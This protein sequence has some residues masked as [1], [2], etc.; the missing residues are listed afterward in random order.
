MRALPLSYR[1][2][3]SSYLTRNNQRKVRFNLAHPNK[4]S[5]LQE[6]LFQENK[7]L[8]IRNKQHQLS[9]LKHLISTYRVPKRDNQFKSLMI[10]VWIMHLP[11][12][13]QEN[14]P[15]PP[16]TGNS[17]RPQVVSRE[18]LRGLRKKLRL[19]LHNLPRCLRSLIV[20]N[21]EFLGIRSW[22]RIAERAS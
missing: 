16:L 20:W 19:Y 15:N 2:I 4:F 5:F 6:K 22:K 21:R 10:A 14:N 9:I 17:T 7:V 3:I 8:V 13:R 1:I 11:E 18:I 12:I